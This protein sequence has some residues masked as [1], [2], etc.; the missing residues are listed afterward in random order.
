MTATT[1]PYQP[2][3]M[4][5]KEAEQ[6]LT[7]SR[8]LHPTD[9]PP[10]QR[11]AYVVLRHL[12]A[13]GQKHAA[14]ID[15]RIVPVSQRLDRVAAALDARITALEQIAKSALQIQVAAATG[16]NYHEAPMDRAEAPKS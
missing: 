3:E 16:P 5:L 9:A 1:N 7:L 2:P 12:M 13:Q 6:L 10:I 8:L 14:Q 11:A 4:T 15:E